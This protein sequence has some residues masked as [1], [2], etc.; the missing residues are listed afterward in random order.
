[1]VKLFGALD[2]RLAAGIKRNWF[3]ATV[4]AV[5]S[6]QGCFLSTIGYKRWKHSVMYSID[7]NQWWILMCVWISGVWRKKREPRKMFFFREWRGA[8]W[9]RVFFF[10]CVFVFGWCG[11]FWWRVVLFCCRLKSI[12]VYKDAFCH[13]LVS[14]TPADT[15]NKL[16]LV[17]LFLSEFLM[18]ALAGDM[19]TQF[20]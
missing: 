7:L 20:V 19:Q 8:G 16:K 12:W 5:R 17:L 10:G 4:G 18:V 13:G 9:F 1:M 14:D 15:E 11:F 3:L 6:K 2:H